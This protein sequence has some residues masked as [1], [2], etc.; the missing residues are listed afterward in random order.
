MVGAAIS[1]AGARVWARVNK[2]DHRVLKDFE[3][4][5]GACAVENKRTF[6]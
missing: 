3:W 6:L 1:V 4:L 2:P 5:E